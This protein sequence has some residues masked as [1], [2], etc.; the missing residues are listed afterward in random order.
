MSVC[1]YVCMSV[2]L[3]ACM[4]AYLCLDIYDYDDDDDDEIMI[5]PD[6]I[7]YIMYVSIVISCT[8]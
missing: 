8:V 6:M 2:C 4:H 1:L 3:H 7:Y 5:H